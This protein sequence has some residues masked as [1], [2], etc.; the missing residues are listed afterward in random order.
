MESKHLFRAEEVFASAS[1]MAAEDDGT[2]TTV[3]E[4]GGATD[5]TWRVLE[6]TR[7]P[8]LW[9]RLDADDGEVAGEVVT[10]TRGLG[11]MTLEE[12]LEGAAFAFVYEEY[13]RPGFDN[14][15]VYVFQV[16]MRG[17]TAG[18]REHVQSRGRILQCV[19]APTHSFEEEDDTFVMHYDMWSVGG[20]SAEQRARWTRG[21]PLAAADADTD[22]DVPNLE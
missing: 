3:Y 13:L 12:A 11:G 5:G 15:G 16:V 1:A 20:C 8:G 17:A 7:R 22:D 21:W 6:S 2:T 9:T 19:V 4:M 18:D 10:T 14:G